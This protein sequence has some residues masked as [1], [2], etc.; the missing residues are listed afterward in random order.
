M[1]YIRVDAND[2]IGIGHMMRCLSIARALRKQRS[3]ATFFVADRISAKMVAE[4]GYGYICLHSDYDHLEVEADRLLQIM[5]EKGA[6]NLLV[7]SYFVTPNYLK[8]IREVANVTYIDDID[9]F[10]YPCDLLIN[11]NIY[12]HNLEYERRYREAGLNTQFALGLDYMPLREE[13]LDIQPAPHEGMRLLVTTGATD[14]L[15]VLA[16]LLREIRMADMN[17]QL[18]I[19]AI[20]GR[21]NENR[22]DLYAEFGEMKNVHLL[23]PQKDLV[24]LM[25]DCDMAVTAG[26]TTVYELCAGGIP[27]VMLTIADNQMR[28]AKEFSGRGIIPYAGDVRTDMCG[29]MINVL[30]ELRK[31]MEDPALRAETTR[32]MKQV[33]DGRG[34]DRL[35]RL[36]LQ[37]EKR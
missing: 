33:V 25:R 22:E 9:K 29:T 7:D 37:K 2:Q 18:E 35:A 6:D 20:V 17:E 4:A 24:Q 16:H 14:H 30:G 13:Y 31:Y 28:A 8:A 11:Y 26:G 15:N 36:L 12:A 19:Y 3:E 1:Y 34:A 21:Y 27:S 32:K 23:E 10:I 5:R